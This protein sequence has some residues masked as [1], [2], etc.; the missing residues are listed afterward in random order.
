LEV[1][2]SLRSTDECPGPF[3]RLAMVLAVEFCKFRDEA[4]TCRA[5]R[6]AVAEDLNLF[7]PN[8]PCKEAIMHE[9][10]TILS[11]DYDPVLCLLILTRRGRHRSLLSVLDDPLDL[12]S[13]PLHRSFLQPLR[14]SLTPDHADTQTASI[15]SDR[16]D[17]W[18]IS[19]VVRCSTNSS[20]TS[21]SDSAVNL[22]VE[23]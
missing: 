12:N 6:G 21:S 10:E 3:K 9:K 7:L 16:Q 13:H 5:G 19:T 22:S 17:S 8:A 15:R 20:Q 1:R 2:G 14:T 23:V 18:T 11:Q 4:D